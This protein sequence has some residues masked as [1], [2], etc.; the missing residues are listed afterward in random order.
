MFRLQPF[1]VAVALLCSALTACG[2]SSQPED[3]RTEPPLVRVVAVQSANNDARAFTGIVASRIQSDLGFR[4]PGK[5]FERLVDKGQT[6][7]NGQP[8]LRLDPQDLSLQAKAQDQAVAAANARA[9]QAAAD[10]ARYRS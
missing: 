9:K 5:I 6:V 3:P 7:K 8:L 2:D 1:P 10:E 4:V